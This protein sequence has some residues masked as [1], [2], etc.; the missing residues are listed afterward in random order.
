[1][2]QRGEATTPGTSV[3]VPAGAATDALRPSGSLLANLS[4]ELQRHPPFN[5]MDPA[6][7]S[8]FV[9]ASRQ[10]YYAPGEVVV[11]PE[12]GPVRELY[13]IRRGAVTGKRGL[14]EV[15]GGAFQYE[16]GDLFPISAVLAQRAP[17]TEYH[18]TEDT[19]VLVIA[20]DDMRALAQQSPVF[21]DFLNRRI[22][23]FLELS[24]SALQV[25][26]SSQALAE[27]SLETP[28]GEL[29]HKAPVT[30]GPEAPLREVL[31]TMQ[32]RRIGSMLVVDAQG[33][34]R[35]ILT[36]SDVLG[37]VAL[38]QV[39]LETPV[40]QVMVSP[41]HSLP[42]DATAQ[43][44][45][46]LMSTH[47]IQHVPV[48]RDG[49]L[50][51]IVSER[52]LFALQR[53]SLKQVS[54]SIRNAASVDA[55]RVVAHDIRRFAR[56]L[57]GQGVQARQLT[58]LISHLNDALTQRLL[59]LVA[60]RHGIDLRQCCWL[61]LGSEGRSEQTIA[62]DQDN[63][64]IRPEGS[65]AAP[66]L[67]FAREVNEALDDCGY[68]LCKG[69]VMAGNPACNLTPQQWRERFDQWIEHGSPQDLLNAS[70]FFDFRALA[71]NDALAHEL[72]AFVTRR[73]RIT[74]RFLHQLALNSLQR[75][76]PLNWLGNID[77]LAA[78]GHDTLD[79]KLQGTAIF[80][81]VAR[82][83]ALA[84]GV[85]HTNTRE[86]LEA[87]G[88]LLG[89]PAHEAEAWLGGFDYLQLLRL[90]AQLDGTTV[91]DNPNRIAVDTLNDIDRRILK[92]TLRV[93]RALQQR[94]K[95]DYER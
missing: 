84:H 57:L 41:V 26:Y 68:P 94:L 63:A 21:G 12:H 55:L 93:L 60:Q 2:A 35:G 46:L 36:R 11:A 13:F 89:A 19:F 28:L 3:A 85:T 23:R 95:L 91:G 76:A 5:E 27:Q 45:A 29:G 34:P 87:V 47:G 15:S 69:N 33:S 54:S 62:T 66:Y 77:T 20:A 56:T 9:A 24:R 1:M 53:L 43:D 32:E 75:A 51:G 22:L 90:H 73:A 40:S 8:A 72:R 86:R 58:A 44:A 42:H 39:P 48:T 16:A 6:H 14:S 38:P 50:V 25:A 30:C 18:A 59:E 67:A 10:A 83:Y 65:E 92:E 80:V 17:T 4:A 82:L 78:E 61:A 88:P 79:I 37:R 81:D 52:D 31:G 64:L 49:R 7:V 74:P 70:I 71:G